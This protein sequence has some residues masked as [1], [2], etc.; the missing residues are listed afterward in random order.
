[1]AAVVIGV[2]PRKVWHTAVAISAACL[3]AVAAEPVLRSVV[4]EFA[5]LEPA[6]ELPCF[7]G[8]FRPRTRDGPA[9]QKPGTAGGGGNGA[10]VRLFRLNASCCK[11]E[12]SLR[13]SQRPVVTPRPPDTGGG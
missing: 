6:R 3:A 9:R 4:T 11:A 7:P 10:V 5:R 8:L 13:S 12:S 2:D 1:M